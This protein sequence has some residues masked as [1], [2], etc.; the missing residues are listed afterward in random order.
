MFHRRVGDGGH[1]AFGGARAA[2]KAEK[3]VEASA[4]QGHRATPRGGNDT[5]AKRKGPRPASQAPE[6]AQEAREAAKEKAIARANQ[7]AKKRR[8]SNGHGP[9]AKP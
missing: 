5:A 4:G 9:R 7:R 2:E 6:T 1:T 8:R 3:A